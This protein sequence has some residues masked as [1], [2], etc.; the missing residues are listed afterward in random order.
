MVLVYGVWCMTLIYGPWFIVS[1]LQF[2]VYGYGQSYGFMVRVKFN[3]SGVWCI[4]YGHII[5]HGDG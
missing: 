2:M 1:D 4:G 3:G 5:G